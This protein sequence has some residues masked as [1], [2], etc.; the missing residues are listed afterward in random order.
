MNFRRHY[1]TAF[2]KKQ[3]P[4]EGLCHSYGKKHQKMES[5]N[6]SVYERLDSQDQKLDSIL[7][8][9]SEQQSPINKQNIDVKQQESGKQA[10]ATFIK[11]SKKEYLWVGST[12][13]FNKSKNLI[14][15]L[16]VIFLVISLISTILTSIAF[17][18]YST[19]SLFENIWSIILVWTQKGR[20][21]LIF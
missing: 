15:I 9:L 3:T 8:M 20:F 13:E 11:K 6:R 21:L 17:K 1:T 10:L 5:D 7:E 16:S 2:K 14:I 4:G 19:F 12:K 18:M